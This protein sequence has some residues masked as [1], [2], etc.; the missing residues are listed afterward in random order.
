MFSGCPSSCECKE[1]G[2]DQHKK[3]LVTGEDLHAVPRD[4]PS[5]TGAVYVQS[6]S[7]LVL[8]FSHFDQFSVLVV[9]ELMLWL[10]SIQYLFQN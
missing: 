8:F 10:I 3:I 1:F 2:E 4:L 5:N 9:V 6:K 7:Q